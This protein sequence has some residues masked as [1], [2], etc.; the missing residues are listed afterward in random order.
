MRWTRL[1]F[2]YLIGYL[3]LGG[4]G[5]LFAPDLA[6]RLLGATA[7]YSPVLARFVGAFMVALAIV[8]AQIVR[9]RIEVLYP[10]TLL[11]RVVLIGTII[12][13]YV[14]SGDR[15]FLVLTGIVGLG[16]L[17]TTSGLLSDRRACAP[18]PTG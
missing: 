5:L 1:S 17:L 8:I 14:E 18:G 12:A 15:L 3:S 16:M 9:H 6:L 10:T 2:F 7:T 11:L 4:V 13:L